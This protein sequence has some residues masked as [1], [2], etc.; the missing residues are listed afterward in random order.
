GVKRQ[1]E[2]ILESR[3]SPFETIVSE[4]CPSLNLMVTKSPP[5]RHRTTWK[6]LPTRQITVFQIVHPN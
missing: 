1:Q 3:G 5:M 4:K 6:I 2:I